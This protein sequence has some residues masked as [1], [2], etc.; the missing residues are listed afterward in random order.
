VRSWIWV[1]FLA[2]ASVAPAAGVE[3]DRS[4]RAKPLGPPYAGGGRVGGETLED[5]MP[6]AILPYADGGTTCGYAN[7]YDEICPYPGSTA[8]E[9]VYR[10]VPP[11]NQ[12]IRV[13]LCSSSYDTKVYV[14]DGA[15]GI[16]VA[17]DDDACYFE[18]QSLIPQVDLLAGHVYF[19]V[20]DGYGG[21]C[22]E[23]WLYVS[24]VADPCVVSCP[25]GAA[26]EGEPPCEDG[27][28]DEYNGGC[29]GDVP[30]PLGWLSVLPQEDGCASVC[31]RSCRFVVDGTAFS[32]ADW[33]RLWAAGG[34]VSIAGTAEFRTVCALAQGTDCANLQFIYDTSDPCGSFGFQRSCPVG[35]ELWLV[36]RPA[37]W[38]WILERDYVIDVCGIRPAPGGLGACCRGHDCEVLT[39]DEC[40]V[41]AGVWVGEQIP[42]VPDPCSPVPIEPTSWGRIK[43][44]YR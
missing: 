12:S 21:A 9:V 16:D 34:L 1:S 10:Y 28:V 19:I 32:D 38:Y 7:D 20:I 36:I 4:P 14:W 5:A 15:A 33:Y 43:A 2:F 6:I 35:Q 24:E 39:E 29:D 3:A 40:A 42:C 26:P 8:P 37:V 25:D 30:Y 18:W 17:C 11:E 23:Y 41:L 13:D 44:R 22:G 27:Y 31:G